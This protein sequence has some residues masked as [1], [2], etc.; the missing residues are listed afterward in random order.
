MYLNTDVKCAHQYILPQNVQKIFCSKLSLL[1]KTALADKLKLLI[2][3]GLHAHVA[4]N[5]NLVRKEN[6]LRCYLKG[7]MDLKYNFILIN[8]FNKILH[9]YVK[10]SW[11]ILLSLGYNL[12]SHFPKHLKTKYRVL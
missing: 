8:N 9:C 1:A 6:P 5:L 3:W 11:M 10:G 12:W 2:V 7:E 4:V